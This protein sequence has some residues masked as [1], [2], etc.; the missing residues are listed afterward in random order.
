MEGKFNTVVRLELGCFLGG[1]GL[2]E[3]VFEL[4]NISNSHNE[5]EQSSIP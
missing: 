3:D 2:G 1:V 5:H 4:G